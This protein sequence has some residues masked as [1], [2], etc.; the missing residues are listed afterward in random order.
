MDANG[1]KCSFTSA[2]SAC[3]QVV[4][5]VCSVACPQYT[6]FICCCLHAVWM[7]TVHTLHL[8]LFACSVDVH[9]THTS[10]AAVCV[11]CGC[12]QYTHFICWSCLYLLNTY[13]MYCMYVCTCCMWI[14]VDQGIECNV[15]I[16]ITYSTHSL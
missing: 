3:Q 16:Y 1:T 11:Q 5:A 6:H 15:Y 12:P 7:S 4:E 8:L 10:S 14:S 2:W 9:S 13:S